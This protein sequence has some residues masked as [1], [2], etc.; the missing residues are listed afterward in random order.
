M[1]CDCSFSD[2]PQHDDYLR[3]EERGVPGVAWLM[4]S[5]DNQESLEPVT[6]MQFVGEHHWEHQRDMFTIAQL[7]AWWA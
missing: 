7:L 3:I 6:W 1:T 2:H 4:D 5:F